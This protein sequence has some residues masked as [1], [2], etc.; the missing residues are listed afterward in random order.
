MFHKEGF[1]IITIA[2][3]LL[4]I[5]IVIL[6]DF[7]DTYLIQKI[8]Q[9]SLLLPFLGV[10]YFYRNP[11]RTT[12][13]S[14]QNIIAPINGRI[15]LIKEIEESNYFHDKRIQITVT[16]SH[17]NTRV[18]RYPCSGL[19]KHSASVKTKKETLLKEKTSKEKEHT[20]VV[21]STKQFGDVLYQQITGICGKRIVNYASK[22]N[23]A[24]QGQ[25]AGFMKFQSTIDLILP[26]H[27]KICVDVGD[28]VK[29]GKH[30]LGS[31]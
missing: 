23:Q 26:V 30:I 6:D 19:I 21:I 28:N 29:G 31:V 3:I 8:T 24:I 17:S 25:D 18:I 16:M 20:S 14:E 10:L 7:T 15:M 2:A 11:K 27:T 5:G 13:R 4:V 22:R 12:A 1:R 9:I